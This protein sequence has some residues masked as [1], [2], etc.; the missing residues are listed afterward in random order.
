MPGLNELVRPNDGKVLRK[1]EAELGAGKRG[2]GVDIGN[3][4]RG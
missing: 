1:H 2:K 4:G 3:G